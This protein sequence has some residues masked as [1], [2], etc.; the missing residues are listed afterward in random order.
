MSKNCPSCG[1]SEEETGEFVRNFC[2]DCYAQRFTLYHL[3]DEYELKLCPRC[4]RTFYSGKWVLLTPTE[5]V[6]DFVKRKIKSDFPFKVEELRF[7]KQVK[8][9]LAIVRL[10]FS[11]SGKK[12]EKKHRLRFKLVKDLCRDCSLRASGY[13]E[14]I[15][16]LRGEWNDI[17]KVAETLL[18]RIEKESFVSKIE[19]KKEGVNIY[20]GSKKITHQ[21][22]SSLELRFTTSKTLAGRKE[23]KDLYRTTYCVRL[24]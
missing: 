1:R 5:A 9:D 15:I 17:H 11:M 4:D 16:Q 21:L 19:E 22:L 7:E 12:V 6:K 13:F 8:E 14:A 3:P 2:P 20:V 23:G 18:K 24:G 10:S